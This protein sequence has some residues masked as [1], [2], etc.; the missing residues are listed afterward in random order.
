MRSVAEH[1]VE[2]IGRRERHCNIENATRRRNHV[3]RSRLVELDAEETEG[4]HGMEC[5]IDMLERSAKEDKK[6][7]KNKKRGTE[8]RDSGKTAGSS[9]VTRETDIGKSSV[10]RSVK[11]MCG[12]TR[13]AVQWS[14]VGW[15]YRSGGLAEKRGGEN[16]H[17]RSSIAICLALRP[18]GWG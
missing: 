13:Q 17:W 12:S 15:S 4:K 16:R 7:A 10:E 14:A 3:H 6:Q 8:Y 1:T 18:F 5:S 2:E 11:C 9:G